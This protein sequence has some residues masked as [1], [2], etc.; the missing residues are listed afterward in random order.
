[1]KLNVLAFLGLSAL[2]IGAQAQ[3]GIP[4]IQMV[5][6][7]GGCF[8]MGSETGEKHEKPVF[9]VCVNSFDMG[10]TEITQGQWKAIM[11]NNPSKFASGDDN[12]VETVSWNEA[13]EFIKRLNAGGTGTYRL[14]TEAEWE[15]ACRSGGKDEEYAGASAA[16]VGDVAWYNKLDAGNMTHPVATKKPNGLG[17]YDMSGNV[18]EWVEDTFTTPYGGGTRETKRVLRGGSW[19]G[20]INYVRCAIRNRNDADRRDPRLGFRVVR[21]VPK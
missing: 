8:F 4:A 12:P 14:P 21:D 2:A 19:D 10:R 5:R 17:L 15:Y 16:N 7:P 6:V 11:G 20:K 18:W 9:K 13:Q 3:S 1:M